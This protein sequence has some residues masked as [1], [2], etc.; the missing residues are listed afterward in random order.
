VD[1]NARGVGKA[2]N[3]GAKLATGE[4]LLFVDADTYL[5]SHFVAELCRAFR[6]PKV[7]CVSGI[8]RGL[9]QLGTLD[10]LFAI[11]HYGFLNKLA[12]FSAHVGFPMF[13]SVCVGARKSVFLRMGGFVEDMAVAEDITFSQG[14]FLH[15]RQANQQLRQNRNVLHVLQELRQNLLAKSEAL[16]SGFPTHTHNLSAFVLGKSK[17]SVCFFLF[18]SY[19]HEDYS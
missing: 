3:A 11:S 8:L 14:C 15:F 13:P 17:R 7:V 10:S 9:E 12:A 5:D 1:L 16:G 19:C 2:R 18:F 6:D 4:I